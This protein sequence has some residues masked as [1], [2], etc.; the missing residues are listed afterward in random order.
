M[1]MHWTI[2]TFLSR[3]ILVAMAFALALSGCGM[4][5]TSSTGG[6][7]AVV[8]PPPPVVSDQLMF[9]AA[10]YSVAQ[11]G[12]AVTLTIKRNGPTA[13]AVSVDFTTADGTAIAGADYKATSG[14]VSWAEND[15][16][17]QT[18]AVPIMN[19]TP[20]VGK[21]AFQVQLSNPSVAAQVATP[22]T[23]AVT[24]A[25]D[26]T[27]APPPASVGS[28]QLSASSYTVSQS[29]GT[30]TVTVLRTGG[31][32]GAIGVTYATSNGTAVAGTDFT[33]ASGTLSWAG[34]DTTSKSFS[35]PIRNSAPF[36]G[37]K[38][39]NVALSAPSGGA[40]LGTPSSGSVSIAGDAAGAVGTLQF[41]ASTYA[42]VQNA[43]TVN[44]IVD[45]TGGSSGA[46]SVAY[47]TGNGTA[48][49]GT[50]FTAAT[51]TLNWA[52]GDATPKTFEVS[53]SNVAAFAGS[54]SFGVSLSSP[55]AGAALSTPSSAAVSITGL[56]VSAPGSGSPSAVTNLQLI[57]Q[58]GPHNTLNEGDGNSLTNYQKIS[59]NAAAPGA[60][61]IAS[62]NIYRNGALYANTTALSYADT[63]A[64]NSN[65]WTWVTN[66]TIYSYN[67]AAVDTKGNIG[68][69]AAQMSVY[70]YQNGVSNWG[71]KAGDLSYGGA[72]ANYAS[73]LGNPQGG[74]FDIAVLFPGS[75]G[76]L[77]VA[78]APQ[79]PTWDLEL[80]AF[81]YFVIDVNPGPTTN[82]QAPVTI[83]SR[84]PPGDV[85]G[86][87]PW[88]NIFDYGP[89]PKANTWATY[90]IPLTAFNL[91]IGHF[92]GSISGTKLTVTAVSSGFVDA[93]G[94]VTGPGIPQGT[95]VIAYSQNASIGTFT[96]AGPGIN[97]STSVPST[98]MTF[99]RTSMYK[100]G[101]QPNTGIETVFFNNMGFT[102]N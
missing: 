20:F 23:A 80:G 26:G 24:I 89:A 49:G 7:A 84:L 14:T 52:G 79:A 66:A 19:A 71:G 77:P 73:V 82:Y 55:S 83:R 8:A 96:L 29:A 53:I 86:W 41:S 72:V 13:N 32:S 92:T 97:A 99:Q 98:Q 51:G 70:G 74:L 36:T 60:N 5:S 50:D 87:A 48:V 39:F 28:V 15:S 43:G 62:Y 57:N 95:Y 44:V 90:K 54:K 27:T 42:V 76:F 88:P 4:S 65:S 12:G 100:F 38:A 61:P 22:N 3:R 63:A 40:K 9:A 56:G 81:N 102:V 6:T 75:G 47:A 37:N 101:I 64:T 46:A 35:V 31:S 11:V 1:N 2:D 67:V 58:G 78:D 16:T 94:F 68:P 17:P 69:Q 21:K 10:T 30:A 34:G 91:G 59:W 18:V 93:G 33:T 25:G 85:F 45:R